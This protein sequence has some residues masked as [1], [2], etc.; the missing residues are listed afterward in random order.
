MSPYREKSIS[1]LSSE[2]GLNVPWCKLV[3]QVPG[4]SARGERGDGHLLS[5]A[6]RW[7][8]SGPS[9]CCCSVHFWLAWTLAPSSLGRNVLDQQE[10]FVVVVQICCYT[11]SSMVELL[12]TTNWV[13]KIKNPLQ[14]VGITCNSAAVWLTETDGPR[15]AWSYSNKSVY[16]C[17]LPQCWWDCVLIYS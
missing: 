6:A 17:C 7:K 16:T 4:A 14:Q 12:I 11:S 2:V 10:Y 5:H 13:S 8:W 3:L 9:C 1:A 15:Q